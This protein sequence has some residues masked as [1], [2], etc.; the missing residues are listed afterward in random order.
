M[1]HIVSF[2]NKFPEEILIITVASCRSLGKD[3]GLCNIGI[4][5]VSGYGYTVKKSIVPGRYEKRRGMDIILFKQ[6]FRQITAAVGSNQYLIQNVTPVIPGGHCPAPFTCFFGKQKKISC[7]TY[8]RQYITFSVICLYLPF[9]FGP[10]LQF[11]HKLSL[12]KQRLK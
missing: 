2:R 3:A 11:L 1:N 5:I 9:N 6:R 4:K 7:K 8:S 12:V 10:C